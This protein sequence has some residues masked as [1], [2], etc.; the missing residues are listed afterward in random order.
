MEPNFLP[1]FLSVV[2]DLAGVADLAL[3]CGRALPFC[4]EVMFPV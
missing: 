1:A 4:R 2:L 3:A